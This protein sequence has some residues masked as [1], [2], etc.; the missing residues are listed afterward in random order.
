M[1]PKDLESP[2][3]STTGLLIGAGSVGKRHAKVMQRRYAKLLVIDPAPSTSAWC[4]EELTCSYRVFV[5]IDEARSEIISAAKETTAVISN[6]GV[7]HFETFKGIVN[8]GVERLFVEKPIAHSQAAIYEMLKISQERK[9]V[10]GVG[11]QRRYIGLLEQVKEVSMGFCGGPAASVVVH[12]GAKCLVTQGMHWVDF[13]VALF[14]IAPESVVAVANCEFINPRSRLLG[15][16]DGTAVWSF[17]KG[18]QLAISYTNRSSV[19]ESVIVYSKNGVAKIGDDLDVQTYIRD[20][21]EVLGDPRVTRVGAIS[22][23][24]VHDWKPS[25]TSTL[26]IQLDDLDAGR[27]PKHSIGDAVTSASA[28]LAALS[29]SKRGCKLSL[30]IHTSDPDWQTTWPIS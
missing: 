16:W 25:V 19:S 3:Q 28:L 11:H 23:S 30:P 9:L 5:S 20:S 17:P 24:P 22:N 4:E 2:P 7:D 6:W 10:V 18:R 26:E 8:L 21:R 12:G 29:S 14:G 1:S 13:A 15:Y 27:V